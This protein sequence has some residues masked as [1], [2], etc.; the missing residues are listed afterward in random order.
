MEGWVGGGDV[1]EYCSQNGWLWTE[2]QTCNLPNRELSADLSLEAFSA[3][4]FNEIFSGR[5]LR[6][7]VKILQSFRDCRWG[8]SQSLIRRRTFTPRRGC[9]PEK[10]LLTVL[11]IQR[12]YLCEFVNLTLR[13]VGKSNDSKVAG[14]WC[15]AVEANSL[16]ITRV[17]NI[18]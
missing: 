1:V 2:N 10:I 6:Q 9:L 16:F 4:E 14:W 15:P 5:Q 17:H 18:H 11:I 12:W 3:T 13:M 8:Q 7:G